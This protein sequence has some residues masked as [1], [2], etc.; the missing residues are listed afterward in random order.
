MNNIQT[1]NVASNAIKNISDEFL[2]RFQLLHTLDL[3]GCDFEIFPNINPLS[4]TLEF[5]YLSNNYIVTIPPD[6]LI[7]MTKLKEIVSVK[8]REV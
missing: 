3:S 1:L 8:L 5:L 6:A 7:Y 2:D 4:T